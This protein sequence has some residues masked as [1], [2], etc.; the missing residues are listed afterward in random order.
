M[1]PKENECGEALLRAL[2]ALNSATKH[3]IDVFIQQTF[4]KWL[5]FPRHCV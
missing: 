3:K 1:G 2:N 5:L 4:I